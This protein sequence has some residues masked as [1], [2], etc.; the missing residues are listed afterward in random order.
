MWPFALVCEDRVVL[1]LEAH[2]AVP[3][4]LQQAP[5][6]RRCRSGAG[7]EYAVRH[8]HGGRRGGGGEPGQDGGMEEEQE[9]V[10]LSHRSP[11]QLHLQR[12]LLGSWAKLARHSVL[13]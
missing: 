9:P 2:R 6:P 3:L 7:L 4:G 13:L 12:K 8:G 11:L 5:P 1:G 10:G